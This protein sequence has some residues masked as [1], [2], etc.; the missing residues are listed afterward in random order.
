[1]VDQILNWVAQSSVAALLLLVVGYLCRKLIE[2][3]L[4]QSVQHEF[5]K[6]LATF[7]EN[8]EEEARRSEAVRSAGFAALLAQRNS[9]GTKQIEAAQGLWNGVLDVRKG[10][11]V[12]LQL[13]IMKID[14]VVK[15][16]HDSRMQLFLKSIVPAE[17]TSS[18]YVSRISSYSVHQPFV[19]PTAWALYVAYSTVI[20][21]AIAKMQMLQLGYDPRRFLKITHWTSLLVAALPPG[22]FNKIGSSPE[23]DLPWA[24]KRLED[25]IVDELRRSM[26]GE[27]A[28]LEDVKNA[29]RIIEAADK[30]QNSVSKAQEELRKGI[31]EQGR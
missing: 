30:L 31:V 10:L 16:L 19:S 1:M 26:A 18:E 23:Y 7:K 28:G 20:T 9:L 27:S 4:S 24:L 13:E 6:K 2:A 8:L 25:M 5:D 29:Q 12:A 3:R 14:E 17:L 15:E 21:L 22:D 11:S